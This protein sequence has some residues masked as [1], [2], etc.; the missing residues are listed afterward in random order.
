MI[1]LEDIAYVR[2]GVPELE[3]AVDFATRIVG[4]ELIESDEPGVARL[5]ADWRHHCLA[6]VEGRSGVLA[7]GFSVG[8]EDALA[9]T[10]PPSIDMWL[11]A[12]RRTSTQR[13]LASS[14]VAVGA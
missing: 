6:F 5:R 10:E 14:S 12:T 3:G 1:T 9:A 7:T 11:G 8:D 2:S 4:L 13:Q